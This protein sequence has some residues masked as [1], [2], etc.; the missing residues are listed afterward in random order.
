MSDYIDFILY[1]SLESSD[2]DDS[3]YCPKNATSGETSG[4]SQSERTLDPQ[5]ILKLNHNYYIYGL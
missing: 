4:D 1:G 2:S 3:D 5:F